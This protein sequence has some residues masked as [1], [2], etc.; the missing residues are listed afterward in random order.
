MVLSYPC[1][2]LI[3]EIVLG[4]CYELT[5][6]THIPHS[7]PSRHTVDAAAAAACR[8]LLLALSLSPLSFPATVSPSPVRTLG[9]EA[10]LWPSPSLLKF[11]SAVSHLPLAR[12]RVG[13]AR[14]H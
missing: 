9:H 2:Y 3:G 12:T 1:Y 7:H 10:N 5:L 4:S 6:I 14:S 13:E 8:Q 11:D